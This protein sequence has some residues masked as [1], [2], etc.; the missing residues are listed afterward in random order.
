VGLVQR[1]DARGAHGGLG[2]PLRIDKTNALCDGMV[3]LARPRILGRAFLR[4]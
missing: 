3:A 2:V 4:R 1:K